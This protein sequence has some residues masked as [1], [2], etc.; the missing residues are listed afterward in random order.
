MLN[1]DGL[2]LVLFCC[3]R[4]FYQ[5]LWLLLYEEYLQNLLYVALLGKNTSE[6]GPL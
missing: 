3:L 4:F 6:V 1:V 5:S 2:K